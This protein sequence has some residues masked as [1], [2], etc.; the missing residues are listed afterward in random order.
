MEKITFDTKSMHLLL[1]IEKLISSLILWYVPKSQC[2]LICKHLKLQSPSF[3]NDPTMLRIAVR[4][5]TNFPNQWQYATRRW[6]HTSRVMRSVVPVFRRAEQYHDNV[7]LTD[8][9]G[10]HTYSQIYRFR[11]SGS[12][13]FDLVLI[14]INSVNR[15]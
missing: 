12:T 13:H 5:C 6:I 3:Q 9:H 10:E 15:R 8:Q 1:F 7:A 4:T 2:L 14:D 11:Y